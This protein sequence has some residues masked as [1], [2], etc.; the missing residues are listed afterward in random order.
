MSIN[1]ELSS[2]FSRYTDN[3]LAA[4]VSGA[5]VRDALKDLTSRFPKLEKLL[6]NPEGNLMQTYD[7]FINGARFYPRNMSLPLKDGDKLNVVYVIHGG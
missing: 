3:V 5:T 6:I 2:F 4:P 1:I 7:L